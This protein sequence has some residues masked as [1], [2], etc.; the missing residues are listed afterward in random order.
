MDYLKLKCGD[1]ILLFNNRK[2]SEKHRFA[3]VRT[4]EIVNGVLVSKYRVY[5]YPTDMEIHIG[6]NVILETAEPID[7]NTLFVEEPINGKV[8]NIISAEWNSEV[9]DEVIRSLP[10]TNY[11]KLD[12][13]ELETLDIKKVY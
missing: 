10:D 2:M 8:I 11:K 7:E 3:V 13:N 5:S 12:N 9:I 4:D 1:R 6:D